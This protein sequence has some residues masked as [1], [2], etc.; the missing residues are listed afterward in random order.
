MS[1]AKA[2]AKQRA[3]IILGGVSASALLLG[4]LAWMPP[5]GDL[6]RSEVGRLV[7]PA[8][9]SKAGLVSM[10]TVTTGEESYHL[11]RGPQGWALA[12][13]GGYPVTDAKVQELTEAL[14]HITYAK[15]MTRDDRKFDRIG[16]GDP[17]QGGTGALLE[18]SDG[19][20]NDFARLLVG[21]RDGQSYVRKPDDLQAW[22]VSNS[23]LPPLQRATAWL[24]LDVIRIA[25]EE[26]AGVDVRPGQ[27]V[28]Y[29]V[30][31]NGDGSYALAPPHNARAVIAA[32]GPRMVA[33]S[34]TR[35]SPTD[36]APAAQIAIG[37]PVADHIT[38]LASGVAIVVRCWRVNDQGWVTV[39]A[40]TAEGAAPAA[41]AQAA[42]I[43]TAT[44]PWAFAL[45]ELDWGAFTT[46]LDVISE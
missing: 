28:S 46:P 10:V 16:L 21:Y 4:V 40:A 36:V 6:A 12:E 32:M 17:A 3:L 1:V 45:T 37:A 7:L 44:A 33:E 34:L 31:R 25:A 20:G 38:R 15:A 2:K 18:V 26:I 13:K 8:F 11:V 19:A 43:N 41:M 24:D 14:A 42:T 9:E 27:G 22:A 30:Q 23:V 29:R 39:S 5:A 35:L